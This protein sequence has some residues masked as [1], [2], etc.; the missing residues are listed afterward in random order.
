MW[1]KPAPAFAG[2]KII[3]SD[4][5]NSVDILLDNFGQPKDV[6]LLV[7]VNFE[8]LLIEHAFGLVIIV[9]HLQS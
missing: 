5:L 8:F 6:F 2:L 4:K 1:E 7:K 9:F 3:F